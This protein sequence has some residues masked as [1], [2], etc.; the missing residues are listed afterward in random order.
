MISGVT[1]EVSWV[2]SVAPATLTP[3]IAVPPRLGVACAIAGRGSTLP[4]ARTQAA[5]IHHF[6]IPLIAVLL[7]GSTGILAHRRAWRPRWHGALGQDADRRPA[8][9]PAGI[10]CSRSPGCRAPAASGRPRRCGRDT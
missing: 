6:K 5:A 2:F 7:A 1:A 10:A 9:P 4:S 8:W 3:T